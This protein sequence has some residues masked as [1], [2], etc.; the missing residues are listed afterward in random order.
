MGVC[1]SGSP[2][3]LCSIGLLL[4]FCFVMVNKLSLSP[5]LPHSLRQLLGRNNMITISH[6]LQT[7]SSQTEFA[8][9]RSS[10]PTECAIR[11]RRRIKNSTPMCLLRPN[12]HRPM[13]VRNMNSVSLLVEITVFP[14][15][16]KCETH[17]VYTATQCHFQSLLIKDEYYF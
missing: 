13:I 4:C 11:V 9:R 1:P 5:F 2:P 15:E 12:H 14:L 16:E 8:G 3:N 7:S 6:R 17:P 10:K